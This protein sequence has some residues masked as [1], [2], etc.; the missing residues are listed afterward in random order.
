MIF[1]SRSH[2]PLSQPRNVH[3]D[4]HRLRDE[5]K[6]RSAILN[7]GYLGSMVAF[8]LFVGTQALLG[9]LH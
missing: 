8:G 3:R 6:I 5:R 1:G 9:N 7:W 4:F 2:P